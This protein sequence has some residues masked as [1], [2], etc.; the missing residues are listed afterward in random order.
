MN[1]RKFWFLIVSFILLSFGLACAYDNHDFQ[2]WNTDTE[3]F[4]INDNSKVGFEQEL[5]WGDNANQFFYQ[6]YDI[7]YYYKLKKWLQ[8][9]AGYRQVLELKSGKWKGENQPFVTGTVYWNFAGCAM[10]SRSRLEYKH[11]VYQHDSW[12]YRNKF[13]MKLP[14]KFTNLEIQPYISEEPFVKFASWSGFNQNR[15]SGG[16]TMKIFK[17]LTGDIYYMLQSSKSAGVWKENNVLGT[18]FKLTF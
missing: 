1:M 16:L 10:D 17:N 8:L 13:T 4:K 3:E 11:Y 12:T 15:L 2:V 7:G 9:G 14:W 6:H 18:K 5:R